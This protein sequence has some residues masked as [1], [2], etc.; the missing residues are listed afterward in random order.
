MNEISNNKNNI[1]KSKNW[2]SRIYNIAIV[3][4]KNRCNQLSLCQVIKWLFLNKQF[5][6][7]TIFYNIESQKLSSIHRVVQLRPELPGNA[8]I[9][10]IYKSYYWVCHG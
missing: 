2:N 3:N 9:Q 4:F 1:N 6:I 8:G 5:V 7:E 10:D